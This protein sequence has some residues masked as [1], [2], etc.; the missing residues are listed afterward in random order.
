MKGMTA[1]F[2]A[3]VY[4]DELTQR[5]SEDYDPYSYINDLDEDSE[6]IEQSWLD[7]DWD[8]QE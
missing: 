6:S 8:E 2:R 7:F 1:G 4:R 3:L 5:A